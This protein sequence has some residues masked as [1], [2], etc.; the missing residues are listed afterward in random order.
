M[1]KNK[2]KKD[3]RIVPTLLVKRGHFKLIIGAEMIPVSAWKPTSRE[4][5]NTTVFLSYIKVRILHLLLR[6]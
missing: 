1:D 2:S 5:A 3:E 4:V 6:P